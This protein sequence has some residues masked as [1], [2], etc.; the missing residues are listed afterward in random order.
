MSSEE[1]DVSSGEAAAECS[2][3]GELL[4]MPGL[5]VALRERLLQSLQELAVARALLE[6]K[7]I[8]HDAEF[9]CQPTDH[10]DVLLGDTTSE[11]PSSTSIDGGVARGHASK[12]GLLAPQSPEHDATTKAVPQLEHRDSLNIQSDCTDTTNAAATTVEQIKEVSTTSVCS[13]AQVRSLEE[14]EE[15]HP[16]AAE[17]LEPRAEASDSE[18]PKAYIEQLADLARRL[19]AAKA[20]AEAAEE[21]AQVAEA[22]ARRIAEERHSALEAH[23]RSTKEVPASVSRGDGSSERLEVE[24]SMAKAL[25]M[26]SNVSLDMD[27]DRDG[28][29]D[30]SA[31]QV[32][33]LKGNRHLIQL[34][35]TLKQKVALLNQ[36][37]L[38]LR[39]DMLYL[40]H[41]MQ[42]C[43]QWVLQ[44]LRSAMQHQSQEHSS[45]QTRFERLSKVLN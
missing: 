14:G 38:L 2:H 27:F 13:N 8:P 12:T 1:E 28:P 21:R 29:I 18:A 41:E 44:S 15:P 25:L 34:L 19:E 10:A 23:A 5:V 24:L 45:L 7:G 36:Q 26:L 6:E 30:I 33:K 37:Y 4:V 32:I 31:A 20:Y 43:R 9:S 11:Q 39:G 22:E 3:T 16:Q 40:N 35:I 42:V 17:E